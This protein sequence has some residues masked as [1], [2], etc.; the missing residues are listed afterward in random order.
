MSNQ[1]IG[2]TMDFEFDPIKSESNKKSMGL[3]LLKLR[4]SGVSLKYGF[5]R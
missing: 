5:V 1:Y 3:I 4:D 2:C